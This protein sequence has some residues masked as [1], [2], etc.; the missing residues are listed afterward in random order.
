MPGLGLHV[1][2]TAL[3]RAASVRKQQT[4]IKPHQFRPWG[5]NILMLGNNIPLSQ[6]GI[7]CIFLLL[8]N[9]QYL[10]V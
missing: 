3:C 6:H 2:S 9:R 4:L 10:F 5:S 8:F 1:E 7:E